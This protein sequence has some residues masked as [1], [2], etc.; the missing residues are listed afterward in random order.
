MTILSII[1]LICALRTNFVFVVIFAT[2]VPALLCLLGA[3]WAWADDY[4][5]N[6]LLAQRLCVGAGALL[7]VTS[8][9]GWYILLAILLAIVDFPIQ[10]PVG[11]LSSVIRGKSERDVTLGRQKNT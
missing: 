9:A 7:F 4:T 10:I 8:F 3:F 1:Y 5:G 2:L 6:T 11:D